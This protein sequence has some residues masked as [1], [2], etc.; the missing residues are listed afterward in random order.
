MTRL[1]GQSI[2]IVGAL[3]AFPIRLA[4]RAV[5]RQ[6]GQLHRGVTRRTNLIVIGRKLLE[7]DGAAI[8][9]GIDAALASGHPVLS[10]NG[11]LRLLG[12]LPAIE[13]G[14]I[15]RQ[16]LLDQSRLAASELTMLS[17]FDAF[18]HDAE[19]YSFRDLILSRKYAGL[20]A[21]GAN[22]N[23]IARSVHRVGSV[24]SLTALALHADGTET[25]YARSGDGVSEL[26]G[27]FR[28]GIDRSGDDEL[29]DV[30]GL[31]EAAEATGDLVAAAALYQRYLGSDP[32][33]SIAAFNRGNCLRDA[34]MPADAT[35][36]YMQAIKSDPGFVEA[37][38]NLA[39]LARDDGR[40]DSARR[41]LK[42][43]L[44]LDAAYGDAI[45]N[46]AALEYDAG[47]LA[48]ARQLWVRYLELDT[49]SEWART[50]IRGIEFVDRS[51][52]SVG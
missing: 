3:R 33:D 2:G 25:I 52:K 15:G 7:R 40:V 39:G 27:Q 19:P 37:W 28:L 16:A 44:A 47:R 31:A 43:A 26:D 10:E 21:A 50:A 4:A 8:D 13:S 9:Q 49:S 32:G 51:L 23:A 22:W 38:F 14:T 46:L 30:F 1:A 11:F 20:L 42:K 12:A 6:G 34:G 29:E 36:A 48:E 24:T 17:L 41:Y 18:E 35:T 45:Y 5:E